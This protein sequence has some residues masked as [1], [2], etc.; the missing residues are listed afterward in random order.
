MC[1]E[2]AERGIGHIHRP[3]NDALT[4]SLCKPEMHDKHT[5]GRRGSRRSILTA[6]EVRGQVDDLIKKD[7][8]HPHVAEKG[9]SRDAFQEKAPDEVT[10]VRSS[11]VTLTAYLYQVGQLSYLYEF[12]R[13]IRPHSCWPKNRRELENRA[14]ECIPVAPLTR[15]HGPYQYYDPSQPV[16]QRLLNRTLA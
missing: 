2:R 11:P 14:L 1:A 8:G 4:P 15:P 12:S 3:S 5:P 16:T 6:R 9:P 10:G 7:R 13:I